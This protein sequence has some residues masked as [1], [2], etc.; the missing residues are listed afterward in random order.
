MKKNNVSILRKSFFAIL[1][2]LSVVGCGTVSWVPA[3]NESLEAQIV[4]GQK[5]TTKFY[6]EMMNDEV[7]HRT[8]NNYKKGYADI[9]TE[10]SSI[11]FQVSAMQNNQLVLASVDS[12]QSKWQQ[13]QDRHKR[14]DSLH[15]E[16]ND[17]MIPIL[18]AG[19]EG[20]WTP[21]MVDMRALKMVRK[22]NN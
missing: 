14:R 20:F 21:L 6:S 17:D 12:L 22:K 4:S 19:M 2:M 7:S 11:R 9:T 8:Y 13:Y 10:I 15:K 18:S 16:T 5:M 1:I 3:Y